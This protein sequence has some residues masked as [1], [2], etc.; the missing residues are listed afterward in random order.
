MVLFETEALEELREI[1]RW[2]LR[3]RPEAADRCFQDFR[4]TLRRI[5]ATQGVSLPRRPP[6]SVRQPALYP[7]PMRLV[8]AFPA[9]SLATL[10]VCSCGGGNIPVGAARF[11]AKLEKSGEL[12]VD[13][14]MVGRWEAD[15]REVGLVLL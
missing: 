10:L 3:H 15:R 11:E 4:A 12:D 14:T 6:I 1:G 8:A 5:E 2:Y 9:L 13:M 7:G